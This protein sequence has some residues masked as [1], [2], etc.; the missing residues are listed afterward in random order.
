MKGVATTG[1]LIIMVGGLMAAGIYGVFSGK[2]GLKLDISSPSYQKTDSGQASP[3]PTNSLRLPTLLQNIIQRQ[4]SSSTTRT[5]QASPA[6]DQPTPQSTPSPSPAEKLPAAPPAQIT[7][8]SFQGTQQTTIETSPGKC[9]TLEWSTVDAEVV[10]LKF[11]NLSAE[12]T[13]APVGNKQQCPQK[14][15]KFDL[16]A[17]TQGIQTQKSLVIIVLGNT[18]PEGSAFANTTYSSAYS[19]SKA[20]DNNSATRWSAATNT[21]SGKFW[22]VLKQ[23]TTV[24]IVHK[25]LIEVDPDSRGAPYNFTLFCG[26]GQPMAEPYTFKKGYTGNSLFP[27][28]VNTNPDGHGLPAQWCGIEV[29]EVKDKT[30]ALTIIEFKLYSRL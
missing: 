20:I 24:P 18:A 29:T 23:Q 2:I 15:V 16:I 1:L 11:S 6:E 9:F 8:F 5:P 12:E 19:P 10:K 7:K 28:L 3:S 21:Y 17:S 14:S 30:W 13:V 4:P 27:I 25:M 22:V 26:K